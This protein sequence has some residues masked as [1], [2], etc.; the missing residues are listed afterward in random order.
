MAALGREAAPGSQGQHG[1]SL[2][3]AELLPAPP[4]VERSP[5]ACA[6]AAAEAD[7]CLLLGISIWDGK[8]EGSAP[9]MLPG[10]WAGDSTSDRRKGLRAGVGY[11]L[12][13]RWGEFSC[14]LG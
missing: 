3:P 6:G 7:P 8:R 11:V 14:S 10:L 5:P 1:G 9:A 2:Q 4:W 12:G 13:E